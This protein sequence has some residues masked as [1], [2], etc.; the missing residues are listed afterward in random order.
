MGEVQKIKCML[1]AMNATSAKEQRT[2]YKNFFF[3]I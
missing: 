1:G 3:P 2:K